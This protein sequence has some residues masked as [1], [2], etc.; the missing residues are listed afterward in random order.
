MCFCVLDHVGEKP[1]PPTPDIAFL[2][3]HF[4]IR[5]FST[6]QLTEQFDLKGSTVGRKSGVGETVMKDLDLVQ[7]D[8][9]LDLG[10]LAAKRELLAQ[11][12]KDVSLLR[13]CSL[14]D[15]RYVPT[16]RTTQTLDENECEVFSLSFLLG[17][18]FWWVLLQPLRHS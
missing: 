11:L 4:I 13:S 9:P 14:I 16:R 7:G 10:S 8:G 5:L 18:V 15:Y 12:E 2:F 3:S 6:S 17:T 1:R